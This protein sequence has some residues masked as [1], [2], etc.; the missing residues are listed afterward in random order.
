[1]GDL[2]VLCLPRGVC[3][4]DD[5]FM[6]FGSGFLQGYHMRWFN[7]QRSAAIGGVDPRDVV[8]SCTPCMPETRPTLSWPASIMI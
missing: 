1:M 4:G 7:Q 2:T 8:V 6:L 5:S 3:G